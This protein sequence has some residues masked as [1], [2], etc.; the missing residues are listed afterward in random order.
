MSEQFVLNVTIPSEFSVFNRI[1]GLIN[2][3]R[4]Q[5]DSISF[6][7]MDADGL[8]MMTLLM[9]GDAYTREHAVKQLQRLHDVKAVYLEE[10][11]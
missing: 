8:S 10:R 3:R 11:E 1:S 5:V 7:K 2:K 9:T 6:Q 4:Y